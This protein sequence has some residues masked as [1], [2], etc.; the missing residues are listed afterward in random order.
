ML[1]DQLE[2]AATRWEGDVAEGNPHR[3]ILIIRRDVGWRM[4]CSAVVDVDG[5]DVVLIVCRVLA[6]GAVD[7]GRKAGFESSRE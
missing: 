7:D 3:S 6:Q 1:C 2:G 4:Y 5:R